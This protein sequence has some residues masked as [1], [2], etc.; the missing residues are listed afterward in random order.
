MISIPLILTQA[1]DCSYLPGEKAQS[2]FVHPEFALT[3]AIYGQLLEQGFRRSGDQVYKPHCRACKACIPVRIPVC[4]FQPTRNQQR[5]WRKNR[6]MTVNIEPA[7]F[8]ERHYRLYQR[9]QTARHADGGMANSS[10][11]EYMNFLGSHWCNTLFIEFVL[12]GELLA[13]AIV[14]RLDNALSAVYTFFDPDFGH[15]SLG[16]YA[17]LWQIRQAQ[18]QHLEWLYL[19]YWLRDC[20]KMSYK[21]QFRPIQAFTAGEWRQYARGQE[22]QP[23]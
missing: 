22:I 12:A 23:D 8:Q 9:Y 4:A 21:N 5:C 13:V 1:H 15:L 3:T 18:Q 7:H 14:D 17:V 16:V 2:L 11:D 10:R 6:L 20:Q 19:G